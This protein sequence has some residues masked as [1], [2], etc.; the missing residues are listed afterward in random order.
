[1]KQ[2]S[3]SIKAG[4]DFNCGID[5]HLKLLCWGFNFH[6]QTEVDK[7]LPQRNN[8]TEFKTT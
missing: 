2:D 5:L 7:I 6:G 8:G 3:W 4:W 1:M